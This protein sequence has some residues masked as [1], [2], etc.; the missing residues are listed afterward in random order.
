MNAGA[1]YYYYNGGGSG[2]QQELRRTVE[3]RVGQY[4][5]QRIATPGSQGDTR[6][7]FSRPACVRIVAAPWNITGRTQIKNGSAGTYGTSQINA[8][9]GNML[10]WNH[11]L[12]RGGSGTPSAI[13][14][15]IT[16]FVEG[17]SSSVLAESSTSA[18]PFTR[19]ADTTAGYRYTVRQD[20]VDR[21]VCQSMRWNP[22]AHNNTAQTTTQACAFIPYNYQ[23]TPSVTPS[24]PD[25][26]IVELGNTVDIRHSLVNS[27][28]T[29]SR[30]AEWR[31][32][33]VIIPSGGGTPQTG[34]ASAQDPCIYRPGAAS[35][36]V[37]D[38][39]TNRVFNPGSVL[40]GI[41]S[42]R[43]IGDLDVGTK[44][45]WGLSV[46]ARSH[47]DTR[48]QHSALSCV[49]VGKKPKVQFWGGDV[50]SGSQV[51]TS[52]SRTGGQL[53]SSWA[54]YA[55]ASSGV[56]DSASGAAFSGRWD[57]GRP[58]GVTD[59]PLYNR[60]TFANSGPSFG[61][62]GPI[63]PSE[64]PASFSAADG[65][66]VVPSG[67]VS[68][69]S[70]SSGRHFRTGNLTIDGGEVSG[71]VVVYVRGTATINGNIAYAG[72]SYDISNL[73]QLVVYA[74]NIVINENVTEV[75]GWLIARGLGSSYVSTCGPVSAPSSWL[76]Y[77][78]SPLTSRVCNQPLM[79]NG[80]VISNHLYLKRTGG[81]E[82]AAAG[83]PAEVINLRPD[84]YMWAQNQARGSSSISTMHVRELPP[85]F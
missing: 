45:C 82:R 69:G 47:S 42:D 25:G 56:V 1:D 33:E 22:T 55:I 84:T 81:G 51:R 57:Q 79:I 80:P 67:S 15:R 75:N 37:I 72:G 12:D 9:P 44:I 30:P 32:V 11:R 2:N 14:Y 6:W 23:L 49:S 8:A 76:S 18:F 73:P 63:V 46:V 38:S 21:R 83:Q 19:S 29:K 50:R 68:V 78:G 74:H 85:R 53:Y 54:E 35:C 65:A 40:L 10:Y 70:L 52:L 59:Q 20:D 24:V 28:P 64:V 77:S 7:E 39:G 26:G 3:N 34:G 4:L 5:C 31:L 66:A 58:Y 41:E 16:R 43:V 61:S 62:Y 27:G 71:R 36:E 17:G 48:W 60:L 13:N